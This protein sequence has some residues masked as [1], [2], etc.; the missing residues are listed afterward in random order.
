[1]KYNLGD[2][3]Y[4][5]VGKCYYYITG[6]SIMYLTGSK[7]DAYLMRRMTISTKNSHLIHDEA[8]FVDQSGSYLLIENVPAMNWSGFLKGTAHQDLITKTDDALKIY[9][10]AASLSPT[11][12]PTPAQVPVTAPAKKKDFKKIVSKPSSSLRAMFISPDMGK[13]VERI[14]KEC[15]CGAASIGYI[16]PGPGHS[17]WCDLNKV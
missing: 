2:L 9:T 6:N 8:T 17:L 12:A 13:P 5:V 3:L 10:Q 11:P 7:V 1:M 4:N 15:D 16:K 14:K